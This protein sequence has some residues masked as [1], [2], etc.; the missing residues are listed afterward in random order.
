M[1]SAQEK[2]LFSKMR[3]PVFKYTPAVKTD[4]RK[5]FARVRRDLAACAKQPDVV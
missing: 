4:I 3:Q 1:S 2:K 5:L